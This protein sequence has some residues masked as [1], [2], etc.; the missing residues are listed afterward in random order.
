MSYLAVNTALTSVAGVVGSS[1]LQAIYIVRT[2]VHIYL[3]FIASGVTCPVY[4][5]FRLFREH[6]DVRH[7]NLTI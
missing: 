1:S 3:Q 5:Y 6:F 4:Q 7:N 2:T